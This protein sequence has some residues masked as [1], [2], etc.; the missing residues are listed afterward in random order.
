MNTA[1]LVV[2]NFESKSNQIEE[3][4]LRQKSTCPDI[5]EVQN[6]E[7]LLELTPEM[8]IISPKT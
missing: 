8:E 4:E 1:E 5:G 6:D 3:I 7:Y 2:P